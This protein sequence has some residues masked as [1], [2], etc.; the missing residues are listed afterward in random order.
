MRAN[1]LFLQLNELNFDYIERYI[2][3]D[4]LPNFARFF[5]RHGIVETVSEEE[6]HLANPWIQWPTV[7]TGLSYAEHSVFRLGDAV[8]TD[9]E[10]IYDA[11]ERAGL[12]VGALSPFNAKN[13][14]ED[15]AFFVPDP[16]TKTPFT[17]SK[18]LRRIYD[19]ICQVTDD[20]AEARITARTIVNLSLGSLANANPAKLHRYVAETLNYLRGKIW[21]RAVVCDRLLADTFLTQVKKHDP[22]FA[23]VFLNGAAHMQH[24]YLFS[25]AVYEGE[26]S[27]PEW[28][29]GA[30]DDPLLDMLRA[31]DEALGGIMAYA[32]SNGRRIILATGLHQNAHERETYYYRLNDHVKVMEELGIRY[33]DTYNLMTEDF[34]LT[35]SSSEAAARAER[36]LRGVRTVDADD[37][38]YRETADCAERTLATAEEVFH[39]ENRGRDLYVQLKPVR[40]LVPE[41]LRLK[42]GNSLIED[43]DKAVTLAQVK[44]THHH[45]QGFYSDS[46]FERGQLPQRFP[47]KDLFGVV[48][49]GFGIEHPKRAAMDRELAQALE[50]VAVA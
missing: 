32:A 49:Q 48:M 45:G 22:H 24:H 13:T 37:L 19:A 11:L 21:F 2:L 8:Q 35:F 29:V 9:H 46:R 43:F 36:M 12:K 28:H 4:E 33:E 5:D 30:D 27:N 25:S 31:Y 6:H 15:A 14:T 47:L 1:I 50:S 40:K 20:Y 38:F 42:S 3:R 23:T 17:G 18:D 7:H 41:G 44:N 26:R 10:T 39:T 16:W 34:V